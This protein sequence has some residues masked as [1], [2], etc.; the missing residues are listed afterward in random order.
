M[1]SDRVGDGWADL[2]YWRF[3]SVKLESFSL[4]PGV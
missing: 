1:G 4:S 3:F 2:K